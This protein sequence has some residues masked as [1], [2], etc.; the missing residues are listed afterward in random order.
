MGVLVIMPVGVLVT[1]PMVVAMAICMHTQIISYF[2]SAGNLT[3][4]SAPP[5]L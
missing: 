4:I 2:G 5:P 3:V 1:M